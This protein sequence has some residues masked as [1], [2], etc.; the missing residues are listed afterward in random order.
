MPR[1]ELVQRADEEFY[2]II[3]ARHEVT[4]AEINP[5]ELRKPP[6]K[7]LFDAVKGA[8]ERVSAA[9]TMAM[10]MEAVDVIREPHGQLVAGNAKAGSGR[11]GVIEQRLNLAVLG[12]HTQAQ[13]DCRIYAPCPLGKALHL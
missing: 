8:S 10:T 1:V 4:A 12:I 13:A 5:F 3:P 7:L 9:L 6:R 2:V 11:A